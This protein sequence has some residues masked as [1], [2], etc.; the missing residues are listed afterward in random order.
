MF[1]LALILL[2]LG[3]FLLSFLPRPIFLAAG[4]GLGRVL[5]AFGFRQAVVEGNLARAFPDWSPPQREEFTAR[6]YGALG[7]LFLE[8]L[9][10]FFRFDRFLRRHVVVEG[11]ERMRAAL[12]GEKGLFVMSAHL[13]NWEVLTAAGPVVF[14]VPITMVTKQ[15][16]PAWLHRAVSITRELLGVKMAC[17][18]R[19]M[20]A[21][22]RALKRKEI[23]GIVMDQYA[24]APVGARVP[25]FGYPVGSH[26]AL[27]TL[28]LRT[29]V[30][31]VPAVSVRR[32]DGKYLIRFEEAIAVA[33]RPDES[34]AAAVLRYTALFT[35]ITERWV[36]EFPEQWLWIHR[37]W[38]GDLSPLPPGA[39]GEMLK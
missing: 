3:G 32:P 15:L 28:A 16:R 25:F 9:A 18:P 27:A 20:P 30:P 1:Y 11:E 37:R 35:Q 14:G 31:V 17:E 29:G 19:T 26:T 12:A 23:V 24:G 8:M 2:K 4:R 39:T 38:K 34:N 36:R 33:A 6:Q 13:G 5:A 7:I 21:I 10:S 22:F